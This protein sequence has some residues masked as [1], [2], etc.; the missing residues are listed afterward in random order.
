MISHDAIRWDKLFNGRR[1]DLYPLG[2]ELP[3]TDQYGA[4][5]VLFLSEN[6]LP[7]ATT[8]TLV[9]KF[10]DRPIEGDDEDVLEPPEF[11][12]EDLRKF[13]LQADFDRLKAARSPRLQGTGLATSLQHASEDSRTAALVDDR[14]D[15]NG[16]HVTHRNWE[17]DM[18]FAT[19]P[20]GENIFVEA[21]RAQQL[22]QRLRLKVCASLLSGHSHMWKADRHQR[23][24]IHAERRL[25]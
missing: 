16:K 21:L 18:Y 13:M 7:T 24:E 17:S 8:E 12:F 25:V 20:R 15:P 9:R 2:D 10:L 23:H 5:A 1:K 6:D 4:A 11:N 22:L 14:R 19:T 3:L